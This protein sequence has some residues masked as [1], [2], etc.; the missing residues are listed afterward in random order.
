METKNPVVWVLAGLFKVLKI[1]VLCF[2]WIII[3]CCTLTKNR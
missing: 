2:V 1:V 3:I